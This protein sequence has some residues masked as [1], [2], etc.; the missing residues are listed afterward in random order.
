MPSITHINH[1]VARGAFKPWSE[2]ET[3]VYVYSL[4]VPTSKNPEWKRR[5]ISGVAWERDL[6]TTLA[7]GQEVDDFERWIK[8]EYE[9]PGL[10]AVNKL[11]QG[12]Q[13]GTANWQQILRY[14]AAQ[15]VR[16]PRNYIE[17]N[18]RWE[19]TLPAI[20]QTS[21]Q[22]S[23]AQLERARTD[24]VALTLRKK[25][26]LFTDS[27]RVHFERPTHPSSDR[28]VVR[29]EITTGR[30]FWIKS[31]RQL[32]TGTAA[33]TLCAHRWSVVEPYGNEEWPLS[34]HPVTCLNYYSHDQYDFGG[35]WG[36]EGS[37]I[38][39]P[40][41]PRHLLYVKVGAKSPNRFCLPQQETRLVQ[42]FIVERAHRFVFARHP[43]SWVPVVRP[44]VVDREKYV[45]ERTTWKNWPQEQRVAELRHH[46]QKKS[47]K[48]L[49]NTV[50]SQ[51]P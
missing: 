44:R 50:T 27:I 14:V 38:F 16:T 3:T 41:S 26:N 51:I 10:E 45:V 28:A 24:G 46:R 39:V 13:L 25:S 15:A 5:A 9:D 34:D 12:V 6:Y 23:V 20:M 8:T 48:A 11:M 7:E 22:E 36:R 32:L 17:A 49:S 47:E 37:E 2:D 40:L 4:L 35:G 43:L 19:T 31:I 21:L 29:A 42:R 18:R 30:S 33:K 1:Y